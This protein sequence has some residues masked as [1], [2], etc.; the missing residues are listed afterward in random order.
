MVY[1]FHAGAM[2]ISRSCAPTISDSAFLAAL[3]EY[4]D[5]DKTETEGENGDS[6]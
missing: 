3:K 2:P 5:D 1:R 4:E 6:E